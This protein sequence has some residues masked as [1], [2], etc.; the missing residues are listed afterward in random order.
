MNTVRCCLRPDGENPSAPPPGGRT[1]YPSPHLPLGGAR[2]A[3][4]FQISFGHPKR[5]AH[6]WPEHPGTRPILQSPDRGCKA[7]RVWTTTRKGS[8]KASGVMHALMIEAL[9]DVLKESQRP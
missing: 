5:A 9:A 1:A 7:E 3:Y 2:T 8:H 6:C 4:S